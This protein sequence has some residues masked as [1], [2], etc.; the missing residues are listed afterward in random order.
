VFGSRVQCVVMQV[1]TI[2]AVSFITL[3]AAMLQDD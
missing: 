1:L 2:I 3:L